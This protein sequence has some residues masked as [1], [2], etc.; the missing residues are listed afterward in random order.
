MG[1]LYNLRPPNPKLN[2][3]WEVNILLRYLGE[4]RDNKAQS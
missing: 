4:Q 2:F 3:V 1:G